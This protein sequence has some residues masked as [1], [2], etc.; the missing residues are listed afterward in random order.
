MLRVCHRRWDHRPDRGIDEPTQQTNCR[1]PESSAPCAHEVFALSPKAKNCSW[2]DRAVRRLYAVRRHWTY[3]ELDGTDGT[4]GSE[5]QFQADLITAMCG[6]NMGRRFRSGGSSTS[7][8]YFPSG[9]PAS[10]FFTSCRRRGTAQI[11]LCLSIS[12]GFA[13]ALRGFLGFAW[14]RPLHC[15]GTSYKLR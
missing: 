13:R 9:T 10:T 6:V 5:H 2:M 15:R 11:L 12:D 1:P 3:Q 4:G 8:R 14:E 7:I